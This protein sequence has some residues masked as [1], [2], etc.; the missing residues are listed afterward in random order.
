MFKSLFRYRKIYKSSGYKTSSQV[1]L[2][3]QG[4][5]SNTKVYLVQWAKH[6]INS[7]TA[8]KHHLYSCHQGDYDALTTSNT[9]MFSL[10]GK[11]Y[12]GLHQGH[13]DVS[14]TFSHSQALM[15]QVTRVH[16]KPP[17]LGVIYST[18][19]WMQTWKMYLASLALVG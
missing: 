13:H 2:K 5:A 15:C 14:G 4:S 8:R 3:I 1:C 9:M 7:L 6:D 12:L 17:N 18:G 10:P 16:E 11:Y 19:C